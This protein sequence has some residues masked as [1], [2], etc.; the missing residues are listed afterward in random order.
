MKSIS[1]KLL[2]LLM[3]FACESK[4]SK[5]AI[6]E[7]AD[8]NTDINRI[9]AFVKQHL[10]TNPNNLE[11]G[12][13]KLRLLKMKE[14]PVGSKNELNRLLQVDSSDS[15]VLE[16]C[17]DYYLNQNDYD[18]AL[19]YAE[20][21]ED[22]GA[23]SAGFFQLKSKIYNGLG[24]YDRAIDYIN[25]AILINRSDYEPYYSKGKIYLSF[26]DTTSALKFMEIGLIQYRN[27]Y[28]VLYELSNI[29][30]RTTQYAEA[31]RLID[32]AI[33]FAPNNEDLYIKK[34]E[35]LKG[36]GRIEDAKDVLKATIEK[37]SAF[38]NAGF[39][40][41]NW[42]MEEEKLD[43]T[44]LFMDRISAY[45]SAN[46]QALNLKAK[47]YDKK[48]YLTAS[49]F[50]YE[51]ILAVDSLYE[52]AFKEWEKVKRKRAYLQKLKEEKE[53]IPSFDFFTPRK[54]NQLN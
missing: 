42:Y 27:N 20:R 29:Y 25:M 26:G 28:T 43:S 8:P 11:L 31:T 16:L 40:L 18:A 38:V 21:A 13:Q 3:L 36:Q 34:A 14:W 45:D 51:Q 49:I 10:E 23:K 47:A 32:N 5:H 37:D 15:K 52:D 54:K 53:A 24:E 2:F 6:P 44:I 48:G 7:S 19:K 12:I 41:G 33:E 46:L 50:N 39:M 30:E 1:P 17:T 35:I 22:H 4:F 9:E